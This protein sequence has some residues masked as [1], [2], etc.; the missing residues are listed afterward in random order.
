MSDS[1][2]VEIPKEAEQALKIVEELLG[3]TVVG[4]YLFG[5]A[6]IGGLRIN[7]DVDVLVLVNRPL[8]EATRK[9]LIDRL[10]LISGKIGNTESM[11]PLEV[12]V[13]NHEDVVPWQYPPKNE[14]I[15]GEWLREEFEKG[16]VQEPTYDPDLAIVLAQVRVN[17]VFLTGPHASDILDPV[18]MTDIRR[19]IKES[20]PELMEEMKGD[21]RNVIL[22]LARMWQTV[23]VGEISPKDVA[24]E[25]A[26]PRLPKDHATLLELARKAYRGEFVDK[27]EGLE[28]E[29]TALVFYMKNA[30]ESYLST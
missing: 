25:W 18:P 8:S 12:T 20:L 6:V 17:S 11:R 23:A 26:I 30:I 14:F 24:A 7:S 4:V 3:K 21:E 28:A 5:S 22:T 13:V 29:V 9:K 1:N 16:Q 19:A 15:Y 10:M 27:W 2:N